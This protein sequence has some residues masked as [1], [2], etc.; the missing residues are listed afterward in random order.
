[1][2]ITLNKEGAVVNA[3]VVFEEKEWKEAQEKAYAKLANNVEVPGFRKG[4]APLEMA[5]KHVN[6]QKALDEAINHLVP[7]GYE[8]V[9]EENKD[10]DIILQPQL[11]VDVVEPT[12]LQLTY[13]ITTR[14]VVTLGNYKDIEVKADE[15]SVSEEEINAELKRIQEKNA[16]IAKKD[17]DTV[18]KGDII[19]FDFEGFADGKAFEGGSAQDFELEIGSNK[20]IPGF[21]DAMVGKKVNEPSEINVKFPENY[22]KDLAGKDA[23]FKVLVHEISTK[24]LPEINDDLALDE[25]IENVSTL[26]ELKAYISKNLLVSKE[27]NAKNAAFTKLIQEIV[28]NA[29]VDIPSTLLEQD[30]E[31]GFENFKKQVESQGIPFDKYLEIVNL[32]VEQV[33]ENVRLDS[34]ENLKTMFV[35]SEIATKENLKVTDED[36]ENEFKTVAE[37]YKMDLEEVKKALEPRRQDVA[38]QIY[39]R[40]VTD[41]LRSVNKVA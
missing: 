13:V 27:N 3:T 40:K 16:V 7:K 35:L 10:L 21:E 12:K 31:H 11:K 38:N 41:F 34:L 18:E 9:L 37:Q 36:I 32:T 26:E 23:T 5:K 29:N 39:N 20:F 24:T 30:V 33:K 1:M 19:K 2:N 15:V 25:N 6:P 17:G 8:Q 22:M 14:P 28:K 4:K